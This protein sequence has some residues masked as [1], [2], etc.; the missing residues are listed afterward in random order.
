ME[1]EILAEETP[2]VEAEMADEFETTLKMVL[3]TKTASG[4][5]TNVYFSADYQDG[6]NKEWSANTPSASLHVNLVQP[7]ADKFNTGKKYTLTIT[8]DPGQ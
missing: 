6:A 1:A 5:T 3:Q 7:I 8:E 4:E 2:A